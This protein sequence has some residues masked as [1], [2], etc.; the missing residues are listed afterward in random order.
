MGANLI[1]LSLKG[2]NLISQSLKGANLISQSLKGA[3]LISQSLKGA[4]R[5][6]NSIFHILYEKFPAKHEN[7]K[8][9]IFDGLLRTS[10]F[11]NL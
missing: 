6:C 10:M 1:S 8:F 5:F 11:Q 3:N 7:W 2:A 9:L 4:N